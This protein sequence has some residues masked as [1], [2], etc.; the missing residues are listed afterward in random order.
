MPGFAHFCILQPKSLPVSKGDRWKAETL[1]L[2]TFEKHFTSSPLSCQNLTTAD[3]TFCWQACITVTQGKT[4]NGEAG[5]RLTATLGKITASFQ[6][7]DLKTHIRKGAK[8]SI[9]DCRRPGQ[10]GRAEGPAEGALREGADGR[11]TVSIDA[12]SLQRLQPRS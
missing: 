11:Y 1:N 6:N 3:P 4:R 10:W 9:Q 7:Q 12:A 8:A 2:I 5:K